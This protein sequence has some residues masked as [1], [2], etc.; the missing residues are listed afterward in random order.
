M[1]YPFDRYPNN[2]TQEQFRANISA[3]REHPHLSLLVFLYD[4]VR[5]LL[6]NDYCK[7]Q[8]IPPNVD[9]HP[10]LQSLA[11]EAFEIGLSEQDTTDYVMNRL[12]TDAMDTQSVAMTDSS[13]SI[14]R[15]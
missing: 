13:D 4:T 6:M 2:I 3:I 12:S 11:D 15:R 8:G 1:P 14:S 5:H 10:E 9:I 7:R